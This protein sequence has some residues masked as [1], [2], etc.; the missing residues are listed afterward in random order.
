MKRVLGKGSRG[1]FFFFDTERGIDRKR[2][3]EIFDM[4]CLEERREGR[5]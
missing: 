2:D 5:G 4:L 1:K 3:G